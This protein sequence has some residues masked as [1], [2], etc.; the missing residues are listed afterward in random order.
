L[1]LKN[2]ANAVFSALTLRFY[3]KKISKVFSVQSAGSCKERQAKARKKGNREGNKAR[4]T[5]IVHSF[6]P[7]DFS[8]NVSVLNRKIRCFRPVWH[9]LRFI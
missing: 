2:T 3:G 4:R 6:L 5:F 9:V 8:E 7:K 1:T